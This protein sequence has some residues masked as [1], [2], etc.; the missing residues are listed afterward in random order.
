MIK[1]KEPGIAAGVFLHPE[2]ILLWSQT[3]IAHSSYIWKYISQTREI[4]H[5]YVWK[6]YWSAIIKPNLYMTIM[7]ARKRTSGDMKSYH[8]NLEM[9]IS[10]SSNFFWWSAFKELASDRWMLKTSL[11]LNKCWPL[12]SDH[13]N[14]IT[15]W[16]VTDH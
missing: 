12:S 11:W 8:D 13:I 2:I 5:R 3:R 14:S 15:Y 4:Y 1:A 9:C 10:L 7:A 16:Y 6:Y